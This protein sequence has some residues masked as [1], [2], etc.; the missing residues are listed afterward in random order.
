MGRFELGAGRVTYS[1]RTDGILAFWAFAVVF[2]A[3]GVAHYPWWML[4][5]FPVA[6]VVAIFLMVLVVH[7]ACNVKIE[8]KELK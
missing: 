5:F 3:L 8:P 2:R 1:I 7:I 4:L 6:W